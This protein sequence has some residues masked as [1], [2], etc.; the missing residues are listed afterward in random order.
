VRLQGGIAGGTSTTICSGTNPLP[1]TYRPPKT[2]RL[3]AA[4]SGPVPATIVISPSGVMT[5]EGP[6][7]FVATQFVSLDGLSYAW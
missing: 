1:T 6:P 5:V 4:A 2:V 3:V 7:L